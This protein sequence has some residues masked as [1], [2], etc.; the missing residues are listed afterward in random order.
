MGTAHNTDGADADLGAGPMGG[1][2]G[3]KRMTTKGGG[4]RL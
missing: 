2:E 1:E 4:V 3:E